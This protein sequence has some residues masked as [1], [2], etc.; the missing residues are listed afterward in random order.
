M[1]HNATIYR[2]ETVLLENVKV[3]LGT[4]ST[5]NG[6]PYQQGAILLN[7]NT[8]LPDM[9]YSEKRLIAKL[10]N[11]MAIEF[12]PQTIGNTEISFCVL[13]VLKKAGY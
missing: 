13:N 3:E 11:G 10:S 2:E 6:M 8:T 5:R 7:S 4:L 1:Q 12:Q 9:R